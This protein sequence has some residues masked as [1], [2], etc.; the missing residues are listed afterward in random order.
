VAAEQRAGSGAPGPCLLIFRIFRA[1]ISRKLLDPG[2]KD[3]KLQQ[4]FSGKDTGHLWGHRDDLCELD[5]PLKM[6]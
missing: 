3:Q 2:T 5:F 4:G 6:K 1:V